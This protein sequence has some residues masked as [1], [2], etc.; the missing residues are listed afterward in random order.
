MCWTLVHLNINGFVYRE[1]SLLVRNWMDQ[2][3]R[4]LPRCTSQVLAITKNDWT[5]T[6]FVTPHS[7][8]PESPPSHLAFPPNLTKTRVFSSGGGAVDGSWTV[9]K[10]CEKTKPRQRKQVTAC[11]ADWEL[12]GGR[13]GGDSRDG[14]LPPVIIVL[15]TQAT[16]VGWS[17]GRWWCC[18]SLKGTQN[19]LET[20]YLSMCLQRGPNPEPINLEEWDR[21]SQG[22]AEEKQKDGRDLK[23]ERVKERER[24]KEGWSKARRKRCKIKKLVLCSYDLSFQRFWVQFFCFVLWQSGRP[25]TLKPKILKPEHFTTT[26]R[27]AF[28]WV[29]PISCLFL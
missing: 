18:G 28:Y 25:L 5:T 24:G 4:F 12:M 21:V 7:R 6:M 15:K 9:W 29:A 14:A 16:M 23:Q 26:L 11:P 1:T 19:M 2:S 17:S 22:E 8:S 27:T 3:V 10:S 13:Q 20:L